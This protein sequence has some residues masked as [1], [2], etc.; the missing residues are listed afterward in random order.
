MAVSSTNYKD[1]S[2]EEVLRKFDG[3]PQSGIFTDGGAR[4]NPGPGAWA[5]VK[6][7]DNQIV[8]KL[9][10][11]DPQTTNNRME[12]SAIIA[13]L[14]SCNPGEALTIYSDSDLC[15]KTLNI[16]AV[17]WEKKGWKK[18]GGE[19]KNLDLVRPAFELFRSLPGVKLQWLAAHNGWR[20]NEYA[21]ALASE[22]INSFTA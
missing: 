14:K 6:V 18:S 15:V 16:W 17:N 5:M 2:P 8:E 10:G 11:Q 3:G 13:A 7:I 19:I 20:W 9:V 22:R 21:D 4:P 12:L 1:L